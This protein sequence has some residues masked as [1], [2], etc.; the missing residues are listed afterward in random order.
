[1]DSPPLPLWVLDIPA[2]AEREKAKDRFLVL[3]VNL[4]AGPR[5]DMNRIA[6]MLGI[7]TMTLRSRISESRGSVMPDSDRQKL[8]RHYRRYAGERA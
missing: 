3:L 1:M 7:K 4:Y 8:L 2:G 5:S 6:E